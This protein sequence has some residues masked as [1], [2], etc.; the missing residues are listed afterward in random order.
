MP[1]TVS[2]LIPNQNGFEATQLAI[3]SIRYYT[4]YPNYKIVVYDDFSSLKTNE[5]RMPNM[6]DL[7]FLRD[8][9]DK[10]WIELHEN[11][12]PTTLGHGGAL[13]KLLNDICDTDYAIVM[14]NDT[15]I[16]GYGHLK[17]L[18]E[19]AEADPKIL[20]VVDGRSDGGF[21][22][23]H[24]R[25]PVYYFQYGLINMTAYRDNMQ[26]DWRYEKKSSQ[27]WPF[28]EE[29]KDYYP[30]ENCKQT[31]KFL[32]LPHINR[33]GFDASVVIIDPGAKPYIQVKYY[34]PKGYRVVPLPSRVK[35]KFY[36]HSHISMVSDP[37][38]KQHKK[39]RERQFAIIKEE[40]RKLKD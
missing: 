12:G 40:L 34:N 26:V 30:P 35:P 14:D 32:A 15:Q 36:H 4:R 17:D 19:V 22:N 21:S 5:G 33:E 1:K 2:F 3:A 8:A 39:E 11:P 24:Y 23:L 20:A 16:K 31:C 9:K 25:L 28:S 6:V 18:L 38:K 37:S 10:G 7:E 27:D 13:N 29:L